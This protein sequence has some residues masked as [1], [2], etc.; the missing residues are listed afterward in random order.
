MK[1]KKTFYGIVAGVLATCIIGFGHWWSTQPRYHIEIVGQS[2][3]NVTKLD[4]S[5]V[6]LDE[7]MFTAL[8]I[9]AAY[10]NTLKAKCV[11][12]K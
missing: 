4:T 3:G 7:C 9:D 5:Y 8:V 11:R 10:P 1:D 12:V 2:T 6:D